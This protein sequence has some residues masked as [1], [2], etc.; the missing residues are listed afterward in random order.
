MSIDTSALWFY[1]VVIVVV[2]VTTRALRLGTL[3]QGG[4]LSDEDVAFEAGIVYAGLHGAIF[5]I[6]GALAVIAGGLSFVGSLLVSGAFTLLFFI[7][8]WGY[9]KGGR[10]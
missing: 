8:T 6:G 9:T 10:A 4:P 3:N 7:G 2:L 5:C 1:G